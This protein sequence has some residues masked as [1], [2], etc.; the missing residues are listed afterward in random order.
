VVPVFKTIK[1]A[2][3]T[4]FRQRKDWE[5]G[6]EEI[7]VKGRLLVRNPKGALSQTE[8]SKRG[9]RVRNDA[10]PHSQR[11]FYST[12]RGHLTYDVYREDQVEPKRRVTPMPPKGIDILAAVWVINRRAKRCRELAS[13][14]YKSHTHD[15]AATAKEE[16]LELYR[17]K[18]QALHYL[19]AEGRLA[20]VGYHRFRGDNWAEVLAGGG[21]DFH[22]PCPA[23]VA[24][25]SKAIDQI[26]AKPRG[27][28]EPRLKDA[29]YTVEEYL[30]DK[31]QVDVYEWPAPIRT[32]STRAWEDWEED[33]D[34]D[35]PDDDSVDSDF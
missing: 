12:E 29:R 4:G 8:W 32:R 26:E 14:H 18:G 15:F 2:L 22:R 19:F 35:G 28:K 6:G 20:I 21:Y 24:N 30:R 23:Q 5:Y 11:S 31:P 10:K 1:E 25:T 7:T 27:S 33:D 17:L 34:F 16:K 9:Y 13:S 3:Q